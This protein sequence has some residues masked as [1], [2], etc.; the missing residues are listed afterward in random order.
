MSNGI[1]SWSPSAFAEY[2]KCPAKTKYK[3]I[4]RLP[5]PPGPALARGTAIHLAAEEFINGTRPDVS[6]D[7]VKI[8]P[9]LTKLRSAFKKGK[10]VPEVKL[11]FNDKWERVPWEASEKWPRWELNAWLILKIDVLEKKPRSAVDIT[12]WKTGK[13]KKGAQ[14]YS[15]QLDLYEL[16]A[17]LAGFGESAKGVLVFTDHNVVVGADRPGLKA[18]GVEA[19]KGYWEARVRPMFTDTLFAPNPNFG[20]RWC[21]FSKA[22]GGPC[23][24]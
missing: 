1:K 20:C 10:A 24:Y 5:D 16:V 17:L 19:A 23:D 15:D 9:R 12:D 4:D 21:P 18:E 13:L 3:R 6:E 7:L 14:E 11:A 22:K 8:K 2:Q